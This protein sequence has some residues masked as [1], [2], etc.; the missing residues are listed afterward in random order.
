MQT[1]DER[2]GLIVP[3]DATVADAMSGALMDNFGAMEDTGEVYSF[4]VPANVVRWVEEYLEEYVTTG[5]LG[6]EDDEDV[7]EFTTILFTAFFAYLG[8]IVSNHLIERGFGEVLKAM[9]ARRF[10]AQN[11]S[12]VLAPGLAV[13]PRY[14]G[15]PAIH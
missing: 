13:L 12:A 4:E 5:D 7:G 14:D 2:N 6:L 1:D 11:A 15:I 8:T 3:K 9:G 10:L